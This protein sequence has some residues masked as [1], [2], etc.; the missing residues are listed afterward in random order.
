[1]V[2]SYQGCGIFLCSV[3]LPDTIY[4]TESMLGFCFHVMKIQSW[5]PSISHRTN[6][7]GG[8]R[9]GN[10]VLKDTPQQNDANFYI[11]YRQQR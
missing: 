7:Q 10:S 4:T 5:R 9:R 3:G 6:A 11:G 8:L 2:S 1:M